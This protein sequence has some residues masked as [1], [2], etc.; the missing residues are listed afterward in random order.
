MNDVQESISE[1]RLKG[2]TIAA[3][4][5]ELGMARISVAQWV[6]GRRYPA[7]GKLV[8]EALSRLLNRKRI[9]KKK[10]YRRVAER[11]T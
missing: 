4:A 11:T 5:D 7:N 1:L 9:P 2:W 6:E 8:R 3:I 10:R